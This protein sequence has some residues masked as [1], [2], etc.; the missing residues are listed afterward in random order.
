[1]QFDPNALKMLLAQSDAELWA[2]I[3]RI[4]EANG[5]KISAAPPPKEE[6]EQ[7]RR[8]LSGAEN[9]DYQKA[10]SMIASYRKRGQ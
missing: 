5:I 9:T 2:L 7:L 8:L 10:L 4:A 3:C 6:M 1:M